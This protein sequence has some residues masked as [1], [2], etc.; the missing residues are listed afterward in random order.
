MIS[1]PALLTEKIYIDTSA[2][3]ALLDRSDQYHEPAKTLWPSLLQDHIELM[4]SNYVVSE[5]LTLLQ[6]RLGFNAAHIW[7]K[8]ILDVVE[9]DWAGQRI[10]SKAYELW[11]GLGRHR[12]SLVDCVSYITMRRHHIEKAFCFK[13]A[14]AKQSFT[15]LPGLLAAS[16]AK[17]DQ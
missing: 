4:T 9:I 7:Y 13:A 10:H 14:Y 12:I 2:F 3:Y 15:L 17:F 16:P 1:K 6:Y 11:L 5:T 8:N